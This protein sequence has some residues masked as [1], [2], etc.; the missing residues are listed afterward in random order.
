MVFGGEKSNKT[1]FKRM[2]AVFW[3]NSA[4]LGDFLRFFGFFNQFFFQFYDSTHLWVYTIGVNCVKVI[5]V[6]P[7]VSAAYE[8]P[9]KKGNRAALLPLWEGSKLMALNGLR[10]T[11]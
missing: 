2:R 4:I 3:P 7:L 1:I 11:S 10:V 8:S 5:V 9:F 6:I